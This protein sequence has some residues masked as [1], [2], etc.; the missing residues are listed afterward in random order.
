VFEGIVGHVRVTEM[1]VREALRPGGST[2]RIRCLV[3]QGVI[4][5]FTARMTESAALLHLVDIIHTKPSAYSLQLAARLG[6]EVFVTYPEY[7]VAAKMR[8]SR[9][10]ERNVMCPP[11]SGSHDRIRAPVKW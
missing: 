11:V 8:F 9:Q 3:N 7:T 6:N 1:L 10:A 5:K 4:A 2:G